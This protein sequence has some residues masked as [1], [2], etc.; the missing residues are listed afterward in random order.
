M[1]VRKRKVTEDSKPKVERLGVSK[2]EAARMLG[3]SESTVHHLTQSGE[4]PCKRVGRRVLYSVKT[5]QQ[6]LDKDS[7]E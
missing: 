1:L 3:L 5:L 2:A 6:F 4:L 7:N